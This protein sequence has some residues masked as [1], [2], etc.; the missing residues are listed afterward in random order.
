M[1]RWSRASLPLY[2]ARGLSCS[3]I[4]SST[5]SHTNARVGFWDS[6]ARAILQGSGLMNRSMPTDDAFLYRRSGGYI[7]LTYRGRPG[8]ALLSS[9][10]L[11]LHSPGGLQFQVMQPPFYVSRFASDLHS[12]DLQD[13][14]PS[15]PLWT[16]ADPGKAVARMAYS[17]RLRNGMPEKQLIFDDEIW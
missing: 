17:C 10:F 8:K 14:S 5:T 11:F 4:I 9:L 15:G 1:P 7:S 6:I 12:V 2:G 16:G 3:E 13:E